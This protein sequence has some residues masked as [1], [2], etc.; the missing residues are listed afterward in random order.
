MCPNPWNTISIHS[1]GNVFS[2]FCGAWTRDKKIGNILDNSIE[3]I[4]A[5]SK[6][7]AELKDS[8][9]DGSYKFCDSNL[10]HFIHT[11]NDKGILF[12]ELKQ[13]KLPTEIML[14]IDYNCNLQ[15]RSCRPQ[16]IFSK[17][18]NLQSWKILESLIK[19]YSN[20]DQECSIYCDGAGDLFTSATYQKFLFETDLPECFN[21]HVTTN[22]NLVKKKIKDILR[23]KHKIKH[24]TISLD[25]GTSNTYRK[26]RGGDFL[27]VL[28]G[29]KLLK[30]NNIPITL[31]YV[32]QYEN[33]KE[34]LEYKKIANN[35][36]VSYMVQMLH[37]WPHMT[38]DYWNNNKVTDNPNI[39][40]QLLAGH[41]A[42]LSNDK[43]ANFNGGIHTFL[44]RQS[45]LL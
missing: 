22:G 31:Q 40:Y 11:L 45:A 2:C 5:N 15:C 21:F 34:L 9:L 35:F 27:T 12:G 25:A 20:V 4:Y 8:V 7:L 28:D 30:D 16:S 19:S 6:S 32:L 1:N 23:I 24:F 26:T 18:I 37:R 36:G 13:L 44:K 10:C 14:S 17:S 39:D 43:T 41:L 38:D 3:E 42:I 33:H 29:I